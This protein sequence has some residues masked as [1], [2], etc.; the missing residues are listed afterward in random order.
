MSELSQPTR[1]SRNNRYGGSGQ[2][3]PSTGFAAESSGDSFSF[4]K[5]DADR[6]YAKE[7]AQKEFDDMLDRER[8]QSGSE[9]YDRG[10]RAIESGQESPS[11]ISSSTSS[12][13]SAW[14]RRRKM[15]QME[16]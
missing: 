4:S 11:S 5:S 16:K 3:A 2:D 12:G 6:Q 13:I 7:Q 14:E 10:M 9:D 1:S 8:R 15:G